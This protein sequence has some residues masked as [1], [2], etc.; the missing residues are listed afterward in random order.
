LRIDISKIAYCGIDCS[1]CPAYFATLSGNEYSK[2]KIAQEWSQIYNTEINP[3]D[4]NC[5]GCSSRKGIHFSHCF[6]C[7]IRL[8]A[9]EKEV[10]TC[11]DCENYVCIDLQDFFALVP[12]AMQGPQV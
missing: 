5:Q 6:N 2:E 12:D 9:L 1:G 7:S 10:V 8:C 3:D 11:A 4:I